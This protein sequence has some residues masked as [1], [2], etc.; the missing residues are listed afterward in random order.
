MNAQSQHAIAEEIAA[1][2]FGLGPVEVTRYFGGAGLRADGVQFG[3]VM[4]GVFYL[5]TDDD[6]R[7]AFVARGAAP[8]TYGG[9]SGPVTV[10]TYFE[11][12]AE[13]LED[14]GRLS[15]WAG[16]ALRASATAA[17][18]KRRSA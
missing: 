3:F 12:P 2:I 11:T 16:D 10:T 14:E 8:F 18:A 7:L 13:I 4:K 15:A 1:Q 6:T 17:N 5:R 9:A